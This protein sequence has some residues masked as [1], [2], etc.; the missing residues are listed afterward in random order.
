M[1]I[2]LIVPGLLE[3]R[4]RHEFHLVHQQVEYHYTLSA[5]LIMSH[6]DQSSGA[7]PAVDRTLRPRR[8]STTRDFYD[9]SPSATS[10]RHHRPVNTPQVNTHYFT[11][12]A[13][14]SIPSAQ[15]GE[16]NKDE[17]D[18]SSDGGGDQ[19]HEVSKLEVKREKNRLKQR[20]LRRES[21][22]PSQLII[23]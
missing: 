19:L 16:S 21:L 20:N 8:T 3:H 1:G 13:S 12:T 7:D 6:P 5:K 4:L 22:G 15:G 9:P 14:G 11:R 2:A 17:S 23:Y 18:S 10:S